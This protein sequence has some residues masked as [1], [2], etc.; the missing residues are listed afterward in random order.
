MY[1]MF[2]L[3]DKCLLS[4]YSVSGLCHVSEGK[5]H[6]V[7][8]N[9]VFSFPVPVRVLGIPGPAAMTFGPVAPVGETMVQGAN[10]RNAASVGLPPAPRP[11][12][13]FSFSGRP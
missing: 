8:R 1:K 12:I 11:L 6:A 3:V 4:T 9:A 2:H 13:C 5:M 10:P 7:Y